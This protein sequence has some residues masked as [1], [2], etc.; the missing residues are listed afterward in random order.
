MFNHNILIIGEGGQGVQKIAEI[1]ARAAFAQ[2]LHASYIPNFTVQQRGGVSSAFTTISNEPIIYPKFQTADLIVILSGRSVS[3][4]LNFIAPK[5]KIIYNKDLV[6]KEDLKLI[7]NKKLI[8]ITA[9]KLAKNISNRVFNVIIL[10]K[11][12]RELNL[13][14][15]KFVQKE[16][17]NIFKAKYKNNP[18][19]KKQNNQALEIGYKN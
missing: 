10:G 7:K 19:L 5:T 9:S 12:I 14:D 15:L 18:E 17:E 3:H 13:L 16:L 4:I 6:S 11:I 8:S 2:N 1:L